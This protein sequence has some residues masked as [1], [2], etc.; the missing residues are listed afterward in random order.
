MYGNNK[1]DNNK[2]NGQAR[3]DRPSPA[4]RRAKTPPGLENL[5]IPPPIA[6]SVPPPAAKTSVNRDHTSSLTNFGQL[7]N[8]QAAA[9]AALFNPFNNSGMVGPFIGGSGSVPA[10]TDSAAVSLL[11][12]QFM[13]RYNPYMSQLALAANLTQAGSAMM[14][15]EPGNQAK[16]ST[17]V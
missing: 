5:P 2:E 16:E 6:Y 10:G 9:M 3:R 12:N 1:S 13:S 11:R 14:S 4:S 7:S 15:P 17:K 8:Y